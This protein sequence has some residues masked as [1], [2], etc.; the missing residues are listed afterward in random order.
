[1]TTVPSPSVQLPGD[2]PSPKP[3]TSTWLKPDSDL[4]PAVGTRVAVAW[5]ATLDHTQGDHYRAATEPLL[6]IDDLGM[7][8]VAEGLD[9]Q[10][11]QRGPL[12]GVHPRHLPLGSAV[13]ALVRPLPSQ[14]SRYACASSKLSKRCPLKGVRCVWPIAD[15]TFPLRALSRS[16]EDR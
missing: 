12:L 13:D 11:Q 5:S 15:S 1:M 2:D 16:K 3:D 8:V 4:A 10:W 9:G 6:I 14:R 7:L